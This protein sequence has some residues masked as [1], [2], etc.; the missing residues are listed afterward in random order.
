MRNLYTF[1]SIVSLL[2]AVASCSNEDVFIIDDFNNSPSEQ[3]A[4]S[5][6]SEP[7]DSKEL[8]GEPNVKIKDLL[9]AVGADFAHSLGVNIKIE[10]SEIEEIK[11]FTDQLVAN[12]TTE[13]AKFETIYNYV[14]TEIAYAHNGGVDN[15]PYPV[16]KTKSA[17]CQG[18]A[19]LLKVMCYTQK[20]PALVVNGDLYYGGKYYG[21]HAWNYVCADNVWYVCDPTNKS[22]VGGGPYEMNSL[23]KYNSNLVT[24]SIDE[25]LFEDENFT[26]VYSNEMINVH[27]VKSTDASVVVPYSIQG[28]KI[29][30]FNPAKM[31]PYQVKELI[32]GSNIKSFGRED[33]IVGINHYANQVESIQ[34]DPE[35][36]YF[37]SY[38]NVVYT[39][40]DGTFKV[41]SIAPAVKTVELKPITAYY[42]ENSIKYHNNL[43]VLIFSPGTQ[44]IDA[45]AVEYCPKLHTAYVPN[46]TQLNRNSFSG[47]AQGFRVIRGDYTCIK[48][49]EMD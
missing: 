30:S 37:E 16:F 39:K 31:F 13:K 19:N 14:G 42:K 29:T 11:S 25:I 44:Y 3:S 49:V 32:I 6:F 2:F 4:Q 5:I 20:I 12:C 15:N 26:Y 46:D 48:P 27:S 28:Y 23:E 10:T 24:F 41:L 21:S 43:E 34:I 17:V 47:V 9:S 22:T 8:T 35:N 38:S 40:V 7:D 33:Y 36:E 1:V 45:Y 18:Y